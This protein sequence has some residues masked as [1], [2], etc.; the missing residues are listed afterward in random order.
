[1]NRF[2]RWAAGL[3]LALPVL[4]F[5]VLCVERW[6]GRRQLA[7]TV[8]ELQAQG[9]YQPPEV[10]FAPPRE[11]NGYSKMM[12]AAGAQILDRPPTPESMK[13]I[14]PG[15]AVEAVRQ[16]QWTGGK[17]PET[18][19]AVEEWHRDSRDSLEALREA[20]AL[21]AC[22]GVVDWRRGFEAPLNGLVQYKKSAQGFAAAALVAA[23]NGDPGSAVA[24]MRDLQSVERA[25]AEEP[26]MI[27]QL[28]RAAC[29]SIALPVAWD[30][31]QRP[32]WNEPDLL[33]LQRALPSTN[34]VASYVASLWG[35]AGLWRVSVR[36]PRA[37]DALSWMWQSGVDPGL[38]LPS[39]LGEVSE[40][41]ED[42]LARTRNA[43][44]SKVWHPVWRFAWFD[45]A[46]AHHLR[47][48][49]RLAR[50]WQAAGDAHSLQWHASVDSSGQEHLGPYDSLRFRLT[51]ISH[52]ALKSGLAKALRLETE[53]ALVETGIA[54]QRFIRRHGQ[55][56]QHLE[57]LVPDWL[58]ALP[59]DGMVGKPLRYRRHPDGTWQLWSVG[60]DFKDDDGDPRPLN[61]GAIT[62]HWWRA[63]DAV[64]PARAE[65]A[66][67]AEWQAKEDEK[68][69]KPQRAFRM[70]PA[71]ARRYGLMP[72]PPTNG[73][74]TNAAPPPE[75]RASRVPN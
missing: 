47:A 58:G 11:P 13:S 8:A 3:A 62:L 72:A 42:L 38:S 48:T 29:A 52:E 64:L 35:E 36:D 18:W 25:L 12:R 5:L 75:E 2:W 43:L 67:V 23:R 73:P 6:R 41:A 27:S 40:F 70:D 9:R 68:L 44:L 37:V 60:E 28:V 26:L 7:A 63:R 55:A 4:V 21:A 32:D 50:D 31:S 61:P 53:R 74:S 24:W 22:R 34:F 39:E 59:M 19:K 71:L 20:F 1:V 46:L 66:E 14:R 69:K 30:L 15:R 17:G 51:P 49:D 33:A 65:D 10:L 45:Q 16:T 56:P 54:L 57:E